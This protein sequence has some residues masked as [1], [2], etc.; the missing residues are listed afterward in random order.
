MRSWIPIVA[1]LAALSPATASPTSLDQWDVLAGKALGNQILYHYTNPEA[2]ST[3]TPYTASARREWYVPWTS[4]MRKNDNMYLN[5]TVTGELYPRR[6]AESTLTLFSVY[7][8]NPQSP[9]P[10]SL[11]VLAPAMMIS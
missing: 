3:C 11:L 2:S 7:P 4:S 8:R 10:P 5:R 9:T 1:A 6:N